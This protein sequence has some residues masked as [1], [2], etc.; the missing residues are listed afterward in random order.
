MEIEQRQ[1]VERAIITRLVYE[2]L[3]RDWTVSHHDGK[4]WTVKRSLS[5]IP[6]LGAI[7]VADAELLRFHTLDGQ[8]VGS[9]WLT[10][11]NHDGCGVVSDYAAAEY[12]PYGFDHFIDCARSLPKVSKPTHKLR[13]PKR[14][15]TRARQ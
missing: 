9:A 7:M 6:V 10:Y 14:S 1:E 11:G 8:L 12:D 5:G 2:G 13:G 15:G 3:A 4:G